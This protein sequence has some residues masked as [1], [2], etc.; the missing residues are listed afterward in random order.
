[1]LSEGGAWT[2]DMV[3]YSHCVNGGGEDIDP[4]E[5]RAELYRTTPANTSPRKGPKP[6][7]ARVAAMGMKA[8]KSLNTDAS[9]YE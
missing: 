9:R 8:R 4:A 6:K 3:T 7:P 1:M 2:Q 5:T